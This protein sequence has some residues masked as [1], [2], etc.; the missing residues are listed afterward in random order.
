MRWSQGMLSALEQRLGQRVGSASG[1]SLDTDR[2][3]GRLSTCPSGSMG[4]ACSCG[5]VVGGREGLRREFKGSLAGSTG[6]GFQRG[7]DKRV[8]WSLSILSYH[9]PYFPMEKS[10]QAGERLLGD[11]QS[12]ANTGETGNL[13]D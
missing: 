13:V 2:G 8:S 7:G 3:G 12:L 1:K 5:T 10:G 4:L 11:T 6:E 9:P